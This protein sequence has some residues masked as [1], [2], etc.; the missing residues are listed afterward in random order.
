MRR[1]LISKFR[2]KAPRKGAAAALAM[3]FVCAIFCVVAQA[4][5]LE[6]R[7]GI[8]EVQDLFLEPQFHYLETR[9]GE[10]QAGNSLVSLRWRRDDAISA[11]A[12]LG[13]ESLLGRPR[14]YQDSAESTE[15][16]L[17]EAYIEARSSLGDWRFGR[18]PLPFGTEAGRAEARLRLP[19]SMVFRERWLGLRDQGFS[20]AI[21]N[22]GFYSEWA[23]HNGEGRD[24]LD[25][26]I[27]FTSRW[28]YSSEDGWNLG[29]SGSAGRTT[30][31]STQSADGLRTS[32]DA[33]LDPDRSSKQRYANAFFEWESRALSAVLEGTF[34]ESEQAD[35]I[36]RLRSGHL[37]LGYAW[38]KNLGILVRH[39]ILDP[40]DRTTGDRQDETT[41][42]LSWRG[43]YATSVFSLLGTRA[44]LEGHRPDRHEARLI[45]RLTPLARGP[46]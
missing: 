37:D 45:W 46:R 28:G 38:T 31:A 23:V 30:P 22:R 8:L 15:L 7:I 20:F 1:T 26:Q 27:W 24:D 41:V 34:G 29:A 43:D 11:V 12:T 36:S 9:R 33:G 6:E 35:T 18:V 2:S 19:R 16:A 40:N 13:T 44:H 42:G 25:N 17:A 5:T 21:E 32:L 39:D 3:G 10:F 14:R 4:A